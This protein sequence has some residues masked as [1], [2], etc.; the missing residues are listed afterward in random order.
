MFI[1][2][3]A[4]LAMWLRQPE[5]IQSTPNHRRTTG[6]MAA[7]RAAEKQRRKRGRK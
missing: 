3:R 6:T 7:K 4:L 2:I 5:R 1:A